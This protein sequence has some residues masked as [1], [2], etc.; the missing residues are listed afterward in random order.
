MKRIVFYSLDEFHR[1]ARFLGKTIYEI[2][3]LFDQNTQNTGIIENKCCFYEKS[4][5]LEKLIAILSFL[6]CAIKLLAYLANNALAYS[7]MPQM[8]IAAPTMFVMVIASPNTKCAS[9]SPN[10]TPVPLNM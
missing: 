2:Y 1:S 9:S 8:M 10:T 7:V 4:A 3:S 6:T 5:I